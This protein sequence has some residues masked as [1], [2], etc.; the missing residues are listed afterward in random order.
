MLTGETRSVGK[1]EEEPYLHSGSGKRESVSPRGCPGLVA[2]L[3]CLGKKVG[4]WQAT[5]DFMPVIQL[6]TRV[7]DHQSL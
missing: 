7:H 2:V 3:V 1:V 4:G 5:R 6:P